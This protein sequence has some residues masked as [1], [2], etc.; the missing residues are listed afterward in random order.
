MVGVRSATWEPLPLPRT[1]GLRLSVEGRLGATHL[2][3]G[4]ATGPLPRSLGVFATP[5]VLAYWRL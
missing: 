5:Y 2:A 4:A 1:L 3:L